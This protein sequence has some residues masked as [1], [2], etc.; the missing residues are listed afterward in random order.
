LLRERGVKLYYCRAKISR[1]A[2]CRGL[3]NE[4]FDRLAAADGPEQ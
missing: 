4:L 1:L 2:H 3:G